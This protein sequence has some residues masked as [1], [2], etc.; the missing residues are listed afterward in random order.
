MASSPEHRGESVRI[1][2]LL[3][4]SRGGAKQSVTFRGPYDG[5][6][7]MALAAKQLV[8][9]KKHNIT[10]EQVYEIMLGEA[11]AARP[12]RMPTFEEFAEQWL[13]ERAGAE[14]IQS[15]SIR[16][17][18]SHLRNWVYPRLGHLALSEIDRDVLQAWV[19]W[20]RVQRKRRGGR[21]S[22]V[23]DEPLHTNTVRKIYGIVSEVLFAAVPK[24]IAHNP[25]SRPKGRHDNVRLPQHVRYPAEFLRPNEW[26]LVRDQCD[27]DLCDI[28]D[29]AAATGMREGELI[30]LPVMNVI[31][32]QS[33]GATILVYDARKSTGKRGEPKTKAGRRAI[34]VG[35][36]AAGI[37]RRRTA[38]KRPSDKVFTHEFRGSTLEWQ[39]ATLRNHWQRAVGR[40]RRCLE[41]PP[42]L[43]PV[44]SNGKR[45]GWR[46]D[47]VSVCAC[48]TR[49]HKVTR[50]HDLR[51]SHVAY[52]IELRWPPKKIQR[53]LGHADITTTMNIYGH[54]MDL[55]SA[56]ELREL[57]EFLAAAKRPAAPAV[58][59]HPGTTRSVHRRV[60]RGAF[61]PAASP[62]AV[63]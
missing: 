39:P 33:G 23:S 22:A 16:G 36:Q 9:A 37:L 17:Y 5:R 14:D 45:R 15:E 63:G 7:A 32:P 4:G 50:F 11:T 59:R 44:A 25:A 24:W 29:I 54:L 46:F 28:C 47:E 21:T 18:G 1:T 43:P 58:N 61:R 26:H 57:E 53:R 60:R 41:H 35:E 42:P 20:V 2:W 52:L 34:P 51:G 55:G 6:L 3:G 62:R 56:E 49:L 27:A 30:E 40:A 48:P 19:G 31:F 10:R 12:G 13:Q 8:E 38:G